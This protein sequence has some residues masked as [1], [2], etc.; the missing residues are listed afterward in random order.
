MG[1]NSCTKKQMPDASGCVIIEHK[2][3]KYCLITEDD[4]NVVSQNDRFECF[5]L[6]RV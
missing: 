6:C 2:Q 4:K 5:T 1:W 3:I